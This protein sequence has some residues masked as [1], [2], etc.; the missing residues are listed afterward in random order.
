[1]KI[2][3]IG[4]GSAFTMENWQTNL[5]VKRN[6]RNMLIDAGGDVRWALKDVGMSY[7]DIDAVYISH[8]HTD[9]IGGV[10]YLGFNSYFDPSVEEKIQFIANNEL[11][12]D[13]WKCVLSGGLLS[14]QGK[15]MTLIDYFDILAIKK[16]GKFLWEDIEC[17]IVQ[18]V[19][20]MDGYAIVP[21]FGLMM[22]DPDTSKTIFYTADTQFNPNQ[23]LD[24]YKQAD[25]I[26]QDCETTPFKS[27]VHANWS[28]LCTLSEDIKAKMILVHYQDNVIASAAAGISTEWGDKA[29][30]A[31]FPKVGKNYGF[32]PKGWTLDTEKWFK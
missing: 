9:H 32:V 3:F 30:E 29:K 11:V 27:G 8:L 6:D 17:R 13:S 21:S 2:Q 12:R 4:T 1:M 28:D 25:L 24:F 5:L 23:I 31:G 15:R 14:V 22:T 16:N 10:E 7:K 20:I 26:I 18:S 19:H